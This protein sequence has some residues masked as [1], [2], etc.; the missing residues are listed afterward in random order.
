MG[1]SWNAQRAIVQNSGGGKAGI[2]CYNGEMLPMDPG[3]TV[4]VKVV[5]VGCDR[6][7]AVIE[8]EVL[9]EGP[10]LGEHLQGWPAED[11]PAWTDA[12]LDSPRARSVPLDRLLHRSCRAIIGIRGTRHRHSVVSGVLPA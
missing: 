4:H 11:L 1:L 12:I 2:V 6:G 5:D 10:Y 9:D 7:E 8:F 3:Q